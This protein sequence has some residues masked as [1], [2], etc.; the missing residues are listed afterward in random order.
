MSIL[1]EKSMTELVCMHADVCSE[2][3]KCRL[4][5]G[6]LSSHPEMPRLLAVRRQIRQ[7]MAAIHATSAMRAGSPN[8]S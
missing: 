1:N 6:V 2:L 4:P 3:D 8:H 5:N 7:A